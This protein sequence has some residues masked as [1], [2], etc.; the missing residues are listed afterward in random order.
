MILMFGPAG[1]GKSLQG[2]ILA[3]RHGWLWLSVGAVLRQRRDDA[4]VQAALQHGD[5]LPSK[6]TNQLVAERLDKEGDLSQVVLDGYPR[7]MDQAEA[8]VDYLQHRGNGRIDVVI[9]L[10]VG[11][12]E[13]MRRLAKRGRADD[14]PE[15][16]ARRLDIFAHQGQ[17]I[18][19]YFTEQGIRIE[20]ITASRTVG[21]VHDQIE[22]LLVTLGLVK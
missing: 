6:L 12:E 7:S 1:S 22:E 18:L 2:Q 3:A 21:Q 16:I 8:L 19:D 9:V 13:I 17:P 5:L 4:R 14:T 11:R 20:R 15:A 10:D